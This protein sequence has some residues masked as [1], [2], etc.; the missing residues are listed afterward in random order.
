MLYFVLYSGNVF[1]HFF[2]C[3]VSTAAYIFLNIYEICQRC[4]AGSLCVFVCVLSFFLHKLRYISDYVT[5]ARER[6]FSE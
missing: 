3:C 4:D 5:T 1:I 2:Y 6:C